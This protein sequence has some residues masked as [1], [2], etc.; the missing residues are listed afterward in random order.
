MR[1]LVTGANGFVGAHLVRALS[2][3][4]G[5]VVHALDRTPASAPAGGVTF[6][7]VDLADH[8]AIE[9]VVSQV[10]PELCIH[11]AWYAEPGKYL[12]SPLNLGLVSATLNLA[13]CL[14]RAECKRLVGVGTCFEYD[15]SLGWLSESSA[16][17]PRFLYAACKLATFGALDA[18]T[19]GTSMTFAWARLFY[20]YGPG[21][22]KTRL[23]PSIMDALREGKIA[24]VTEGEQV[25]D[26]LHVS[27]VASALVAVAMS[28]L[29]GPV[30]IASGV[31]VT[32]RALVTEIARLCNAED[33]VK[34]GAVPY[35]PQDPMFVCANVEKLKSTGYRPSFDLKRGLRS[36]LETK[37]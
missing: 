8:A 31:P 15:T 24:E 1:V 32:V 14:V 27:D 16:T 6:H 5:L 2:D 28:T 11:A 29:S 36:V 34:F 30:N 19:R 20:L 21:E 18:Y 25:R 26:F 13:E 7:Q 4:G 10:R 9:R 23:V 35:R 3:R 37:K 17:A 12:E 33:R 22:A